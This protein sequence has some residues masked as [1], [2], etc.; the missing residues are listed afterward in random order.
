[1]HRPPLRFIPLS[2]DMEKI[3]FFGTL[4]PGLLLLKRSPGQFVRHLV[5]RRLTPHQ[6]VEAFVRR[7]ADDFAQL[8]DLWLFVHR[9]RTPGFD[10]L[11]FARAHT[12]L[13]QLTRL[14][15]RSGYR[16]EPL[17]PLSPTVN[18]PRLAIQAGLGNASPYGLLTHPLFG[19]RVILSGMRTDHPLRLEPRWGG[20]GCTDCDACLTLCPQKPLESGV[21]HLGQCQTCALC[22]AVCPTGKGK[23]ARALLQ[24]AGLP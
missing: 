24:E 2:T 10:P 7:E 22:F 20:G 14:L 23:R 1:M 13:A 17:D 12:F 21:I 4:M 18:L 3:R 16:A 6:D 15:R 5:R 11:A 9:W 19:P 8:A